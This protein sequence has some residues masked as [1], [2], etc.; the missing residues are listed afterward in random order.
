MQLTSM[1]QLF[2]FSLLLLGLLGFTLGWFGEKSIFPPLARFVAWAKKSLGPKY[3][4][5][6][7][8]YKVVEEGLR[9]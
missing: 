4:K 9:F 6:R 2:R 8:V 7:K 1:P 5:K 3:Q